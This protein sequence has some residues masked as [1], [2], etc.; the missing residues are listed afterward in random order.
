MLE[1][2]D[3]VCAS[4][5]TLLNSSLVSAWQDSTRPFRYNPGFYVR[6]IANLRCELGVAGTQRDAPAQSGVEGA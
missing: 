6:L 4:R 1:W 3:S 2:V 5:H